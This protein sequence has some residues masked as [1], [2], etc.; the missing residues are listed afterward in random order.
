MYDYEFTKEIKVLLNFKIKGIPRAKI[1]KVKASQI[2]TSL[3][4]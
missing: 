3:K 4:L 1:Q 2:A